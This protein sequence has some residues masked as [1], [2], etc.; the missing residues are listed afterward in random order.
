MA[1]KRML[2]LVNPNAG[3]GKYRQELG[4]VLKTFCEGGWSPTV[5][6][7]RKPGDAPGL[8]AEAAPDYDMVVCLGGDGTL[9]ETAAGMM[10]SGAPCPIGYIPLGT[11]NDVAK[12]LGL[13]VH[14]LESA[15]RI[16]A[17]KPLPFDLG[18]FGTDRYFSYIAAFGAF[19]EVSY[20]TP[21]E[22]KQ[23]L[24]HLAYMLEAMRRLTQLTSYHA[25]VE[26]DG[27]VLEGDFLFGAVTNSTSV[28][29][30]MQLDP[31]LVDLSDGKL[32]ILLVHTP[33]DLL[34]LSDIIGSIMRMDFSGPNVDF[35]HSAGVRFR[36]DRPV[37]WTRDGEDGGTHQEAD[38][39]V[40][41]P[42][43]EIM[44]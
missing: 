32:E 20:A 23:A 12:T 10:L 21:Q 25:V 30:L 29:G 34:D 40:R 43:V 2:V 5:C 18:Q 37:A 41:H 38:I 6:F 24:G 39:R 27:G 8:V 28:G 33:Q 19:T 31:Q 11:A 14:P 15:Q 36:F 4:E 16:I 26:H 22:A 42:G 9:S 7:T 1:G 3:K 13:S 44:V 17:G 35:L